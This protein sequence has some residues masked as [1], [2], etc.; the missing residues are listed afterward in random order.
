MVRAASYSFCTDSSWFT[1]P[2][3]RGMGLTLALKGS[4]MPVERSPM[5]AVK[6]SSIA[7]D[8]K[9][10]LDEPVKSVLRQKGSDVW[11]ISPDSTVYDAIEQMAERGV[12]ALVVMRDGKMEGII[13]ERDYARKVILK[14]KLSHE[15]RVREIMTTPA[16]FVGPED[17]VSDCMRLMT[18][19]RVRH[20]P[21]LEGERVAGVLSIGDLVNWIIGSQEQTIQQ[22]QSYITG[23]YPA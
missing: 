23:S 21:V 20:L 17:S 5:L 13:S 2:G 6:T 12:G 9:I 7:N 16:L 3:T 10:Q 1:E 22:L 15:T 11:S 4:T 8:A 19:N 14:N 18:A